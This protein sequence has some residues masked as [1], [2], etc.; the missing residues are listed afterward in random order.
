MIAQVNYILLS[1]NKVFHHVAL[2]NLESEGV[3]SW[4]IH[5][6]HKIYY[7]PFAQ[8]LIKLLIGI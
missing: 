3:E 4:I 1:I 8:I 5:G 7:H 2:N 6:L